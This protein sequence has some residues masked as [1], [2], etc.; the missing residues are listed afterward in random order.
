MKIL[1]KNWT[2]F[3]FL[4]EMMII[5]VDYFRRDGEKNSINVSTLANYAL[6]SE[7]IMSESSCFA[8]YSNLSFL[9]LIKDVSKVLST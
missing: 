5:L 1:R 6:K 8:E 4:Y 7:S 9:L 2:K 3:S